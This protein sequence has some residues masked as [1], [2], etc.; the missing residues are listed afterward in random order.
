MPINFK[1]NLSAFAVGRR[2][3]M[4]EWNAITRTLEDTAPLDFGVPA[5]AGTANHTCAPLTAADQNVLGITE[6]SVVLP[7]PGDQYAQY[8]NVA[9]CESGVIGVLLGANVTKGAQARYDV[10]NKAWTGAAAS[11]TVL[12]IPGAQFEEDGTSGSVGAVRYR[13]PIPSI[14]T[15]A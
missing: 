12:T 3:N 9:I 13:R 15:G 10:T 5:I 6:A 11:A 8:D 7:R 4:E 1:E 14:A 2:V